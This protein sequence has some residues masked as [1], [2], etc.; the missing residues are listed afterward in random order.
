M[1][2]SCLV[3]DVVGWNDWWVS[4]TW[5]SRHNSMQMRKNIIFIDAK[6]DQ[7]VKASYES[8]NFSEGG[9]GLE[10]WVA[11]NRIL[12]SC[13]TLIRV[14]KWK[15][16]HEFF[17]STGTVLKSE[18]MSKALVNR[19]DLGAKQPCFANFS[20]VRSAVS[21]EKSLAAPGWLHRHG[22]VSVSNCARWICFSWIYSL[23]C[24]EKY[25]C[26]P[27]LLPNQHH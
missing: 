6:I 16:S 24:N 20:C 15:K 4:H 17:M 3:S 19:H 2:S 11:S 26:L 9:E 25:Y 1:F 27:R 23:F 18:A 8:Y 21:S 12:N 13:S 22:R 5:Y 10:T 14:C 7:S